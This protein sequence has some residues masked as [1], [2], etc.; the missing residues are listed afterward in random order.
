[1]SATDKLVEKNCR[2]AELRYLAGQR[3][4]WGDGGSPVSA[5]LCR[6][7]LNRSTRSSPTGWASRRSSSRS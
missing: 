5:R 4:V 7:Q 1:M 6:G 2:L 3:A